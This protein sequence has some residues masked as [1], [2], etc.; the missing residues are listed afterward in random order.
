MIESD[1]TYRALFENVPDGLVVHDPETGRILDANE[2]YRELTGYSREE[3]RDLAIDDV[4]AEDW[5]PP[6]SAQERI[7]QAR[8]EGSVTFEWRNRRRDGSTFPVEVCLTAVEF[9]G[10]TRVLARVTDITDRRERERDLER[11]TRAIDEAPIGILIADAS[12]EDNPTVYV[13]DYFEELTG[14]SRTEVSGRNCRFLQGER[15]DPESVRRLRDAIDS[16]RPVT[17]ELRNYRK[18]GTEFWNEV[19]VAP[20]RSEEG[21]V[22]QY[23]GFQRD[24]TDRKERERELRRY[25]R[26]VENLP[27]GVYRNRPGPEGEFAYLNRE[28]VS[29]FGASS[30]QELAELTVSDLYADPEERAEFSDK[31]RAE[32][33]VRDEELELQ[34]VDGTTLWGSVTAMK[35]AEDGEV[36]FD[37]AIEDISERK[38][39]ERRL[40]DQRDDLELLNQVV[41]HDIRNEMQLILGEAERL[42]DHVEPSG[43]AHLDRVLSCARNVVDL[44]ETARELAETMLHEGRDLSAVCL[45]DTVETQATALRSRYDTVSV[46]VDRSL[47]HVDVLAD[48]MLGSVF[49]NLLQNGVQHND[50]QTPEIRISAERHDETVV[51]RVADNG[52]GVPEE[53]RSAVFG[54]GEKRLD[55]SGTG[56]GLYLVRELVE[57]YGGEVWVEDDESGGAV[58]ALRLPEAN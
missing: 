15:T 13:N 1:T 6:R 28:M 45:R 14:Y 29:L 57:S 34:K 53:R 3:L 49:W 56:L 55:S 58:F 40:Q 32:G 36:Y 11:K 21:D 10:D 5:E 52:P 9:E 12:K 44:T 33:E 48:D 19:T 43:E 18:D 42:A 7:Q 26:L 31:L 23:V 4:T 22:E 47:D 51:V 20:V 24:V 2:R 17:V 35:T 41:R 46:T 54:R 50:R 38:A 30:K 27:I 39:Y 37:G 8:Q 25:E 16:G